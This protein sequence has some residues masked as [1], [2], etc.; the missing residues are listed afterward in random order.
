VLGTKLLGDVNF[1][2]RTTALLLS[3]RH[4]KREKFIFLELNLSLRGFNHQSSSSD[5][6]KGKVHA[7]LYS[8]SGL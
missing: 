1:R 3:Q 8:T 2:T 6:V 7:Q 4:I 5:K